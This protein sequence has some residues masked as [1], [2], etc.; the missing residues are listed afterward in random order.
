MN[1]VN[2]EERPPKKSKFPVW[3]IMLIVVGI[4]III[5]CVSFGLYQF[6]HRSK[7]LIT[8]HKIPKHELKHFM[9]PENYN[10]V[11][12]EFTY[13]AWLPHYQPQLEIK[14]TELMKKWCS[15]KGLGVNYPD[16]CAAYIPKGWDLYNFEDRWYKGPFMV[17]KGTNKFMNSKYGFDWEEYKPHEDS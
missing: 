10:K 16:T 3:A 11:K 6:V 4:L 8:Y 1:R 13:K 15:E 7:K 9:D 12:D 14:D 5:G 2:D 17:S